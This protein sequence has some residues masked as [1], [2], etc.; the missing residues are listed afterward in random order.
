VL[1]VSQVL[2]C[3]ADGTSGSCTGDYPTTALECAAGSS[4]LKN[5]S[6][7]EDATCSAVLNTTPAIIMY[8]AVQF[9]GWFGLLLTLQK[10]PAVVILEASDSFQQESCVNT[11]LVFQ[12]ESCYSG[13]LNHAVLVVGYDISTLFPYWVSRNSWG[14]SWC[15]GG[16]MR[17]GIQG[18]SGV[19][20][21]NVL[22][23]YYPVAAPPA[24]DPCYTTS[25][26]P[27]GDYVPAL[28]PCGG[29]TC[30]RAPQWGSYSYTCT[31]P[32]DFVAV[33]NT[34]TG[35]PAWSRAGHHPD[36]RPGGCVR[37]RSHQPLL[38]WDLCERREGQLQLPLPH[39]L[40]Q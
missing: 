15:Y 19:C 33:N 35:H 3:S 13:N 12:A 36:L 14:D 8:E 20:G 30:K 24:G 26:I 1:S 9:R 40:L 27:D 21:M 2:G 10:Q 7:T 39:W 6:Y 22:P 5:A 18:G 11:K 29:G 31:C 34:V 38:C 23:A 17:L 32:R 16:Y 4:L 25:S 28:N 37:P